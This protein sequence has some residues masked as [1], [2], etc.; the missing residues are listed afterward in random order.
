MPSGQSTLEVF[1][2][3]LSLFGIERGTD[4]GDLW[5]SWSI[6]PKNIHDQTELPL[7]L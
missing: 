5:T 1:L 4:F 2:K 7:L 3:K 6:N